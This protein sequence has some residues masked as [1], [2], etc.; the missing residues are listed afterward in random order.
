MVT[1]EQTYL[2]TY[3]ENLCKKKP[4]RGRHSKNRIYAIRTAK[5]REMLE[6]AGE[7]I[8]ASNLKPRTLESYYYLFNRILY[9]LSKPVEDITERDF[10]R[11][12][13]QL[14]IEFK[15]SY[16]DASVALIKKVWKIFDR[17]DVVK[18]LKL[19]S[20]RDKTAI[21]KQLVSRS[22]LK[23]MLEVA[24]SSRD[25]ALLMFL[26]E[27]AARKGEAV[28]M[29]ILNLEW[30]EH[31]LNALVEGKTGRRILP[32][33]EACPFI[34]R[35]LENHPKRNDPD[36]PLWI[37]MNYST[38]G[39]RLTGTAI[40]QIIGQLAK[41]AKIH[42]VYPHLLRHSRLTECAEIM[43]EFQ[44]KKFA[45]WS[46]HSSMA[47]VYVER[48]AVDITKPIYEANGIETEKKKSKKTEQMIQE[49]PKCGEKQPATARFCA[50]CGQ[51]LTS[52]DISKYRETRET[53]AF[54]K[55]FKD[56]A[57]QHPGII[58]VAALEQVVNRGKG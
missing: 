55:A 13:K 33:V 9:D 31:G 38:R 52:E 37:S 12:V 20:K 32:L 56:F 25:R 58:N 26:F 57:Q 7:I 44:M 24:D 46:M 4:I 16:V 3:L 22:D 1:E 53:L 43:T 36:A 49:C 14:N 45:G 10:L 30:V 34:K 28:A 40:Q 48:K 41:R 27:G 47:S 18:N 17:D 39:A 11:Y 54:G 6:K 35:Y 21:P 19:H 51:G 50:N 42:P 2:I 15:P 23:K 8:E 5:T 29:D